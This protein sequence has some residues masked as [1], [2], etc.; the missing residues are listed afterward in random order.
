MDMG[1]EQETAFQNTKKVL[2]EETTLVYFDS[3]RESAL[4]VD[5][6]PTGLVA[7]LSQQQQDG[8]WAPVAYASRD[9]TETEQRYS[10][11]EKEAIA[12]HW[13]CRHFHLYLY[14][15][16]FTVYTHHKPLVPLFKGSTSKPPPRIEIWILQLKEYQ[17]Q[18]ERTPGL[19]N[20]ADY[21]S[22]HARPAT[23]E[24]E[25]AALETE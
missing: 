4:A 23:K 8:E 1:P 7:V 19:Q 9:L 14:G 12:I 18:V 13:G 10:H 17:L 21:L 20:P 16:P 11:I 6:S 25:Q 22:R 3:R 24:E 15:H 5:A 2:S